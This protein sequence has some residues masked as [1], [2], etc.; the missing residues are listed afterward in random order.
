MVDGTSRMENVI[1]GSLGNIPQSDSD[2]TMRV[3]LCGVFNLSKGSY[4]TVLGPDA[5]MLSGRGTI[6]CQLSEGCYQGRW[7]CLGYSS[8][9]IEH[10]AGAMGMSG[11][12]LLDLRI[13]GSPA[14]M[15]AAAQ[16]ADA[17][18]P[19]LSVEV[20]FRYA[21]LGF[22]R[23]ALKVQ[24]TH[25]R[26]MR[27]IPARNEVRQRDL[28]TRLQRSREHLQSCFM[29]DPS[30]DDLAAVAM[31]SRA[32]YLRLYR[33]VYSSTPHQD[34]ISMK[35]LVASRLLRESRLTIT[36]I[37]EL[38]GFGNRCAF[39]RSFRQRFGA[40]PQMFRQP[41]LAGNASAPGAFSSKQ[42]LLT[43]SARMSAYSDYLQ[44]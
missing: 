27:R 41:G 14:M 42:L 10:Q 33:K 22:L 29:D 34:L 40:S 18:N 4:R 13:F 26:C 19:G 25:L 37:I 23:E 6:Q 5:C 12:P 43:A 9:E 16:L 39:S 21:R 36:E 30:I 2:F 8:A 24:Q 11:Q 3:I 38:T 20:Q 28:Y 44:Q 31:L 32:H 17:C 7:L 1:C 35:L 15:A